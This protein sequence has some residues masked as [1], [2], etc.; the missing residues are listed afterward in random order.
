MRAVRP[1]SLLILCCWAAFCFAG[2]AEAGGQSATHC[3]GKVDY[4]I[5][6]ASRI[7]V[8]NLGCPRA[9]EVIRA[10]PENA[11]FRCRFRERRRGIGNY[12]RKERSSGTT[13]KVNYLDSA[14]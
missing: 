4:G 11:G 5:G 13:V 1:T 12:C 8:E 14:Y 9:K 6:F 10:I 2:P 3:S 7:K